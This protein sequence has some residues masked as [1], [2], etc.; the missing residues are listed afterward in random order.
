[1]TAIAFARE[2]CG[3]VHVYG[4]GNGSCGGQCYH[5]YDCGAN[6]DSRYNQSSFLHDARRSGGYHNFSAQA[7][8]LLRM[9][10]AGE[11]VPHWG[12]CARTLG[13]P[14][15]EFIV[16]KRQ[17]TAPRRRRPWGSGKGRGAKQH[18]G[19]ARGGKAKGRG[20]GKGKGGSFGPTS[21]APSLRKEGL[22]W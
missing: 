7:R 17:P 3:T 5:Y 8:A 12:S 21:P 11:I 14:P 16:E 4:F 15:A 2:L 6:A 18:G 22:P 9:A 10:D 13:D 19:R 1:M 20:G